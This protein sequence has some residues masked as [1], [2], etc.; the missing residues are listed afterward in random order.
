MA[1]DSKS[2]NSLGSLPQSLLSFISIIQKPS[3]LYIDYAA[4]QMKIPVY[5]PGRMCV[6][7]CSSHRTE[8]THIFRVFQMTVWQF[9]RTFEI[10]PFLFRLRS[11]VMVNNISVCLCINQFVAFTPRD[12]KSFI[13][14]L[15]I[16][17]LIFN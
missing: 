4:Y 8:T 7:I 5:S 15:N 3:T 2:T 6:E 9:G 14:K 13:M 1:A 11:F 12:N 17:L 16:I 10:L